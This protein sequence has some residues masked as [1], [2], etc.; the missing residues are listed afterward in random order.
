M[1]MTNRSWIGTYQ[2]GY[3][4]PTHRLHRVQLPMK[5]EMSRN[6]TFPKH[7]Q[8]HHIKDKLLMVAV[9]SINIPKTP[10][11]TAFWRP[12]G[13]ITWYLT[14]AAG[15]WGRWKLRIDHIVIQ[16]REKPQSS[17]A[18]SPY[19]RFFQLRCHSLPEVSPGSFPD[20]FINVGMFIE[21]KFVANSLCPK[22]AERR[23]PKGRTWQLQT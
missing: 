19:F 16:Q 8:S 1:R 13:T 4:L 18:K 2:K 11:Q 3:R 22:K 5:T 15:S 20:S 17:D 21:L 12:S 9:S 14:I 10:L 7:P 6:Y 23:W